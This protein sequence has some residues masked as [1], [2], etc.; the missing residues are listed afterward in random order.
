VVKKST[1]TLPGRSK[2]TVSVHLFCFLSY[3]SKKTIKGFR[4]LTKAVPRLSARAQ[5][6]LSWIFVV[7]D[8]FSFAK[9]KFPR[10]YLDCFA[11][12]K[13]VSGPHT[14]EKIC[15]QQIYFIVCACQDSNLG[16]QRYK[17]CALTN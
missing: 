13:H 1:T 6:T 14:Y 5:N 17:L 9:L 4:V 3:Y 11:T 10:P 15:V 2:L 7:R 8:N 12:A 16:P